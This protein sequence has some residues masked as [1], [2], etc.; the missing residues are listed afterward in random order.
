MKKRGFGRA[1]G[2][3]AIVLILLFA[4]ALGVFWFFMASYERSRPANAVADYIASRDG[5]FW[6]D[7]LEDAIAHGGPFD[8]RDASPEDYGIEL[9]GGFAVSS[10]RE[11]GEG[12]SY[13]L[14]VG[15][16]DICR[17]T[18]KETGRAGFGFSTWAAATAEFIAGN[19]R[20]LRVLAP[21]NAVVTINGVEV[22]ADMVVERGVPFDM[23]P[24]RPFDLVPDGLL[25]E[26]NDLRGPVEVAAFSEGEALKALD[27][28]GAGLVFRPNAPHTL[29]CCVPAGAVVS[30][31][32]TELPE[33]YFNCAE[34]ELLSDFER[35]L[36]EGGAAF[37]VCAGL[38]SAPEVSAGLD[39]AELVPV[40]LSGGL[41]SF[42]PGSDKKPPDDKR[43]AAENF[44]RAYV[45]Y[46]I[47]LDD[48]PVEN[49]K[50]LGW[51]LLP[52]TDLSNRLWLT[53][54]ALRWVASNSLSYERLDVRDYI[55]LGER[56]F[57]CTADYDVIIYTGYTPRRTV[58][59]T[60]ILFVLHEGAW[61]AAGMLTDGNVE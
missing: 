49:L 27:S 19:A 28:G 41:V 45:N 57:L 11:G 31:N 58:A 34:T 21:E 30:V 26:V 3:Y 38:M 52:G 12:E 50:T 55:P 60:V 48:D 9:S 22:P 20:S 47:D 61:K 42:I 23:A 33:E 5:A 29:R 36:G 24:E 40:E 35:Y 14:S 37:C 4:A 17:L 6:R 59:Q 2:I 39:G 44:V 53:Q 46:M 16:A 56:A 18:L 7:G 13:M 15:G 32:G 8:I 1:L 43:A 51:Y 54:D 10:R 25:Y